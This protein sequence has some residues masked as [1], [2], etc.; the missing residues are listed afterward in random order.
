MISMLC[1]DLI[2]GDL[3][4]YNI[5]AAADGP[6]I[7]DFPQVI[8]AVHSSRAEYFFLR[9]FDNIMQ[10]LQSVQRVVFINLRVPRRWE[11]PDNRTIAA[12]VK[13][14]SNTVLLD[15]HNR[16][17]ECGRNVF[18]SDGIHPTPSGAACYARMVAAA[19][20]P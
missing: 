12:G 8:S 1:C 16:W 10:I 14:Y 11:T 18:W 4:P 19:V 15:W 3:S 2:H 7:I 20:Q 13:R 9:D 17:R 5:L 6:T